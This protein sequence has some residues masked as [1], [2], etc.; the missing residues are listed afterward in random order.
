[1]AKNP[2][3]SILW[4]LLLVFIAWPVAGFCAG[5]WILLQVRDVFLL[6]LDWKGNLHVPVRLDS[7]AAGRFVGD[8]SIPATF[9]SHPS[10]SC[11]FSFYC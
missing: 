3:F 4:I 5:F 2:L 11:L 1:M 7:L 6:V 10:K 9:D 8:S